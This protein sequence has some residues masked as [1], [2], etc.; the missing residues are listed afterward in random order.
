MLKCDFFIS[1]NIYTVGY[2]CNLM[3]RDRILPWVVSLD[4][5]KGDEVVSVLS[6]DTTRSV[7]M[8]IRE[9]P[10]TAAGL[11]DTLDISTQNVHYHLR[12][13]RDANL[14][15]EVGIQYSDKNIKMKVYEPSSNLVVC[16]DKSMKQRL[17]TAI[18]RFL[19]CR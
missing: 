14:I 12:K 8:Q 9:N 6:S 2:E 15:Q 17:K 19:N 1:L 7:Y 10:S 5:E 13:L 3:A 18:E 4:D 16:D 11:S